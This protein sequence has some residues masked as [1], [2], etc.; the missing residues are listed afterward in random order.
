MNTKTLTFTPPGNKN[1]DYCVSF[2]SRYASSVSGIIEVTLQGSSQVG[3]S[4][5]QS[6]FGLFYS[7]LNSPI[8]DLAQV[9]CLPRVDLFG[10]GWMP[11]LH[12]F[13]TL[14]PDIKFST[15]LFTIVKML[16]NKKDRLS[17]MTIR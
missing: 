11:S 16:L 8:P 10:S 15:S 6:V 5:H 9:R 12:N 13:L 1:V 3:V 4:L 7:F 2:N 14:S 17:C